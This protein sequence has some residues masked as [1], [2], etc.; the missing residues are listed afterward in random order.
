MAEKYKDE[1]ARIRSDPYRD[2]SDDLSWLDITR[3]DGT[4]LD[5]EE[6]PILDEPPF[7]TQVRMMTGGPYYIL[8]DSGEQ[9]PS[10]FFAH[11]DLDT[12]KEALENANKRHEE[13]DPDGKAVLPEDH[14]SYLEKGGPAAK[15]LLATLQRGI[16]AT[17]PDFEKA[18]EKRMSD[19]GLL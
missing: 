10:D 2:R 1:L 9:I 11:I 4:P 3:D 8:P 12:V 6:I 14:R 19:T 15:K 17:T 18:V 5:D 16:D 13:V 7:V